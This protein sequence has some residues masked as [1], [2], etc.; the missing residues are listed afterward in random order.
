MTF[1]DEDGGA[2]AGGQGFDVGAGAGDAGR[3]D[4]DHLQGAA[5]DFCRGGEDG[6]FKLASVGVAFDGDVEGGEGGLGGVLD[7][8]GEKNG[9]G[10]GAE[11]RRVLDEEGEGV[12]EV[13]AL[14]EFEHGGGLASGDD[15]AVDP[16]FRVFQFGGGA[17]ESGGCAKGGEGLGVSL[18]S[19]LE[20]QDADGDWSVDVPVD[21]GIPP[22]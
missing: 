3:A 10:A 7:F 14:E 15:E 6:G 17:D 12:E 19:S 5:F 4:E 2:V 22:L 9:S 13:I 21:A 1:A 11:G 18:V 8:F 20:G 16:V